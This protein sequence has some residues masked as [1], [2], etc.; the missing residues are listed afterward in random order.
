MIFIYVLIITDFI[1][2]AYY[3]TFCFVCQGIKENVR[4][5]MRKEKN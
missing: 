1:L 4:K 3:S 2:C 5:N